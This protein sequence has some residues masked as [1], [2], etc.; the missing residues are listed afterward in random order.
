MATTEIEPHF[1]MSEVAKRFH[2]TTDAIKKHLAAVPP[3]P[4]LGRVKWGSRTLI[5]ESG[6]QKF[7]AESTAFAETKKQRKGQA[8]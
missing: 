1:T 2:V 7:L 8:A 5:S 3:R 6:I 4:R